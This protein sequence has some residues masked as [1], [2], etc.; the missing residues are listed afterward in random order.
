[1]LAGC[2]QPLRAEVARQPDEIVAET[3]AEPVLP[4]A[5]RARRTRLE[6]ADADLAAAQ[7]RHQKLQEALSLAVSL[8]A[9]ASTGPMRIRREESAAKTRAKVESAAAEL[10]RLSE[11]HE[12]LKK[13]EEQR[14]AEKAAKQA[15]EA[16]RFESQ[17]VV[18]E[19]AT[20]ALVTERLKA[21]PLM[22]DKSN[23][24][25]NVWDHIAKKYRKACEKLGIND[26]RSV[27]TLKAKFSREQGQFR[28]YCNLRHRAMQS[29]ASREDLGSPHQILCLA[30]VL[31][32][33]LSCYCLPVHR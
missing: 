1:M 13:L 24:N 15:R 12:E 31:C 14:E 11:Q 21:T 5:K 3:P 8:V 18:P 30:R 22:D 25:I 23:K 19:E 26:T 2:A 20:R 17:V 6:K 29:G 10:K 27:E 16:L 9:S 4:P 33:A 7:V 28:L 32:S